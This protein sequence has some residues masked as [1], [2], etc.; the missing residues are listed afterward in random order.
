MGKLL[1]DLAA[2]GFLFAIPAMWIGGIVYTIMI[3]WLAWSATRS[4]KGIHRE[5]ERLNDTVG[6]KMTFT[7]SGP[8]GLS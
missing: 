1:T 2:L 7:K 6:G 8:L 5:L 3:P 4:V